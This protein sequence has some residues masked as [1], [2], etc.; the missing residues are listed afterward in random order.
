M[1]LTRKRQ[2][3]ALIET[4]EG[5]LNTPTLAA[6]FSNLIYEPSVEDDYR[7]FERDPARADLSNLE[8]IVGIRMRSFRVRTEIR[9]SGAVGTAPKWGVLL[10]GCGFRQ[11]K[12]LTVTIG[13]ITTGPFVQGE[14]VT[15]GS[16]LMRQ[17]GTKIN[18][19]KNVGIGKDDTL[20]AKI[21]GTVQYQDRGRAGKYV[22][23]LPPE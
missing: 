22:H 17:R 8:A 6:D 4:T 14:V 23:I 20:F 9:G 21:A 12:L 16:I 1:G 13:A 15:G 10:R 19:G 11:E 7:M 3:G 5:T 18:P 2:V